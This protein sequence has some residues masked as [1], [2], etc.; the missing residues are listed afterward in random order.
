MIEI[1][2]WDYEPSRLIEIDRNLRMALQ[3]IKADAII[4]W[5]SEPPLMAREG[6]I[7][8]EPVLEIDGQYW[9]LHPGQSITKEQCVQLLLKYITGK[10]NK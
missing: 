2:I 8:K 6:I 3:Q 9:S 1:K 7:G 5:I 10:D 4:L